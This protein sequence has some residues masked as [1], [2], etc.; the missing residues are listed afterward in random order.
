MGWAESI[1]KRWRQRLSALLLVLSITV[2]VD[3]IIKEGYTVDF[4]DFVS[5]S[6]T[7]EKIFIILLLLAIILGWRG[8]G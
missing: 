2:L 6:I 4:Y 8:R 5:P 3:E 7:H 1:R